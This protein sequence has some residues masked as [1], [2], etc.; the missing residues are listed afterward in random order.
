M[1]D[2]L[3]LDPSDPAW[4]SVSGSEDGR[5]SS[6]VDTL[7]AGLL[8]ERE[9]ARA[10]KDWA[11]ADAIRGRIAAAGIVVEDTPDGPTWT[12]AEGS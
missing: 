8:E 4:H 1:L 5:L 6:A 2:V 12:L 3:G 11:R 7:V 10:E 9:A